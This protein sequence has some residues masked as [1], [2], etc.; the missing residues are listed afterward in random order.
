MR[1]KK[2]YEDDDGRTIVDMSSVEQMP[3]V[4]PRRRKKPEEQMPKSP[5]SQDFS[6]EDR[7]A[8]VLGAI[9]SALLI[10]GVFIAGAAVV[11]ELMLL[12]WT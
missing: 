9:G 4:L 1:N 7:R 8:V 5:T 11:I 2:T 10:G 6:D 3:L 12:A